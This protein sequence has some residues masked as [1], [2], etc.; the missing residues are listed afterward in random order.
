MELDRQQSD[1]LAESLRLGPRDKPAQRWQAISRF[2]GQQTAA[3]GLY[4]RAWQV[5][6]EDWDAA[7]NGPAPI[8]VPSD[9]IANQSNVA[10]WMRERGLTRFAEFHRW[11][12]D[13]RAEFWQQSAARLG[14]R[15]S[16]P[17]SEILDLSQG[18][19][20]AAWFVDAQL[21]I[22]ESCFQSS[23]D[24]TAI[25]AQRPGGEIRRISY[26]QLRRQANRVS[27]SLVDAGLK[28]GDAVAVVLPMTAWSVP[29]YLGIIQAGCLVVS[30]ADSF[31]PPE[32]ATRMKIANA[33]LVFTYDVQVRA[34]K[35]LPLFKRVA[36][37]VDTPAVVLN[38][39][40]IIEVDLRDRDLDWDGFLVERD[41]FEPVPCGAQETIN[42]LFSS[43]TT[44]DPKAIPWNHLTPLKCAVD[45]YLHQ[46][47]R[48][49][50]VCA[51]PTNLGWMMG[52][53]LIFASLINR[54]TIAIYEDA[55]MGQGFGQ[56]V[57]DAQVNML[58][59]VP[60]IVKAW[61]ATGE[62]E[63]FDWSRIHVF[64]STGESS[65]RD[66]MVYL[67]ALAGI[68]PIIEYCG[69]TEIG[70]GYVT[71]TVME[72]NLPA[73]FNTPAVGLDFVLIDSDGQP[74]DEGEVFLIP[75]SVGL[76]N[77]LIN[78][79]HFETYYAGTPEIEGL[80]PLRRHGDHFRRLPGGYYV[81][82][83]RVDDTMNLGGIK[84][85]SAEIER[86]L[87]RI[88]GIIETAAVAVSAD[89][90]PDQLVIYCV[91]DEEVETAGLLKTMN[92][93]LRSQL[94]PLFKVS[95]IKVADSL[96]RTASGKVMRR[97]LRDHLA[98]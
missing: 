59:V 42:V 87:N 12:T 95:A 38:W 14:V 86:V 15:F 31:A 44:G 71:S 68:R 70:G 74:G 56:F 92:A 51:W 24:A 72:P 54:A 76:S 90:G 29:I 62:M 26:D 47:I 36:E 28:V 93:A 27:N 83:G 84:I 43:G 60:T 19:A 73:A 65:Q 81:A 21:N 64:S 88:D 3:P 50:Q 67:S 55:P 6:F 66:E 96:P 22:A 69:G 46:D 8:W 89:G 63:P 78:R 58:G 49:G 16:R 41:Q 4:R 53:W 25:V 82:G 7:S 1:L 75:P 45:G 94:N 52:P 97:K 39:N 35:T 33:K 20:R 11:T 98:R 48:P 5:C 91:L 17:P 10:V 9:S 85:S 57:Q 61:Q 79:D 80:G 40:E 18:V 32:I 23:G 2:L 37:A 30:I 13:H 34:G 77:R